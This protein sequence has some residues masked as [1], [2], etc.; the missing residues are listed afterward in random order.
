MECIYMFAYIYRNFE[1][2]LFHLIQLLFRDKNLLSIWECCQMAFCRWHWIDC[3][4]L[5]IVSQLLPLLIYEFEWYR[6]LCSA[7][8][9]DRNG[10]RKRHKA[11]EACIF[12]SFH[13][14][15]VLWRVSSL[16]ARPVSFAVSLQTNLLERDPYH[17][18][19]C[20]L[21]TRAITGRP[22]VSCLHG[23]EL[24]F[25]KLCDRPHFHA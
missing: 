9:A 13:S 5:I 16:L 25:L 14:S 1:V 3:I 23:T 12:W 7:Q 15:A 21:Q 2:Q 20:Q 11:Y 18:I 6:L 24:L 22:K 8:S 10:W 19:L 17:W 4:F